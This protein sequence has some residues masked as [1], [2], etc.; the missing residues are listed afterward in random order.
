MPRPSPRNKMRFRFLKS[1][2]YLFWWLMVQLTVVIV[3]TVDLFLSSRGLRSI[4]NLEITCIN[5]DSLGLVKV[6]LN[7][8]YQ[9]NRYCFC[10]RKI[11]L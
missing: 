8:V 5:Y 1:Y 9:K 4:K 11:I 3:A 2:R 6:L 10:I 7:I